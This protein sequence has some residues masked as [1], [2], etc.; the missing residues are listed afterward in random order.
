MPNINE[1]IVYNFVGKAI[2]T[3]LERDRNKGR[4]K[5]RKS[6]RGGRKWTEYVT[7]T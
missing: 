4:N 1:F 3:G 5:G 7:G 2:G 6:D